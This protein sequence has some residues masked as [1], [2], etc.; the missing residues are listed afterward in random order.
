MTEADQINQQTAKVQELIDATPASSSVLTR[1]LR[2]DADFRRY[3]FNL[4]W[5]AY[6][7]VF[8][9]ITAMYGLQYLLG[10]LRSSTWALT[11]L[12][13]FFFFPFVMDMLAYYSFR[14]FLSI[15]R[16][17]SRGNVMYNYT[18]DDIVRS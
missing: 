1:T 16:L 10:T 14:T 18:P 4:T 15:L 2:Q 17:F 5:M 13:F 12:G 11:V 6:W 7:L 9:M 8:T 3:F